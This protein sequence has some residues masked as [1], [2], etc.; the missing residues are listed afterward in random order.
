MHLLYIYKTVVQTELLLN[1]L[2]KIT[3][4]IYNNN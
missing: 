1:H 3:P 2:K 4:I